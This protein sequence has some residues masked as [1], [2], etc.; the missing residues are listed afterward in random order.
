MIL[1]L[2]S[3]QPGEVF[4]A[5]QMIGHKLERAGLDWHA[6]ADAL[7]DSQSSESSESAGPRAAESWSDAIDH[8]LAHADDLSEREHRFVLSAG[9][10]VRR[11]WTLS[12][13]Q[14]A[15]LHALFERAGGEWADEAA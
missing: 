10:I 4:A 6:L 11:G 13:K 7:G 14:A 8:I 3:D 9:G 5:A 15:W 1:L 2:S 12:E